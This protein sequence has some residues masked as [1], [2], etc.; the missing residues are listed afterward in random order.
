MTEG[1]GLPSSAS[2]N[3]AI[4][5]SRG[6]DL[7]TYDA[8][9]PQRIHIRLGSKHRMLRRYDLRSAPIPICLW[10][11]R[12]CGMKMPRELAISSPRS[13]REAVGKGW[14]RV[15]LRGVGWKSIANSPRLEKPQILRRMQSLRAFT[16]ACR[17]LA[18]PL[19]TNKISTSWNPKWI[20]YVIF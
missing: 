13:S 17:L 5:A 20:I 3:S 7:A 2:A 18:N 11:G 8:P 1:M 9:S 15:H 16:T 4:G 12:K 14:R 6:A 10:S 19:I